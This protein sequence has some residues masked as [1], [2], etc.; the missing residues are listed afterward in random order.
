MKRIYNPRE[1]HI[2]LSILVATVLA[3]GGSIWVHD[4]ACSRGQEI[5]RVV[6]TGGIGRR[7]EDRVFGARTCEV[8]PLKRVRGDA[9]AKVQQWRDVVVPF[10]SPWCHWLGR[11]GTREGVAEH[12]EEPVGH[13][14]RLES[15]H[16][17]CTQL[18]K[19]RC[20]DAEELKHEE[21]IASA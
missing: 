20:E 13:E 2:G 14:G 12:E 15:R 8:Q 7:L 4:E 19:A 10:P 5:T 3:A 18:S 1:T 21:T 16:G 6:A 17:R 11:E 9:V